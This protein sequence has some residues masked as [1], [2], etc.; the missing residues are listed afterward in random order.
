MFSASAIAKLPP[1]HEKSNL[2]NVIIDTPKGAPYKL[3]YEEKMGI[4]RVH[5]ALPL[6]FTFPFN[7]GFL[8]STLGGDGDPLD[9]LMITDYVMPAGA[10]VLGRMISVLEAEQIENKKKQRNDRL[11]AIPV[12]L[13]SRKPMQ[14]MVEFNAVLKNGNRRFL[15]QVQRTAE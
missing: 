15:R 14:P 8:P 5:K 11:L 10:M 1:F 12:E 4:F 7:F 2:V 9:V 3:K 13:L 6:G